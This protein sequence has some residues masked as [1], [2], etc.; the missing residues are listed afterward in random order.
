MGAILLL[1]FARNGQTTNVRGNRRSRQGL[2]PPFVPLLG[3]VGLN[4]CGYDLGK[5]YDDSPFCL[6]NSPLS[7]QASFGFGIHQI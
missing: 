5:L 3:V 7:K 4:S 1:L 6:N 2:S